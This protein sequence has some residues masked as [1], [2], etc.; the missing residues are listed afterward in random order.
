MAKKTDIDLDKLLQAGA[1]FGHHAK[2]W[3]PRMGEYIYG[4]KDGVHVFDLIK[5]KE[6]LEEA[7]N[8][9]KDAKAKGKVILFLGTKKQVK[10]K[11]KEVAIEVGSPYIDDRFLG[12]TFTNFEQILKSVRKLIEMQTKLAN[13]EYGA[14]TKKEKLLIAREIEKKEKIFGGIKNLTK[15]P[16]VIFV[17]DTHRE[18]GAV[19]EAMTMG[20]T[21]V[22][23]VDTNADPN[24]V[25]YPIPMND[26]ASNALSYVLDLI[27]DALK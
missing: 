19:K 1:H 22:G 24:L 25:N 8:A 17:V 14:Y 10:D 5:T 15:R 16:D 13:G 3:N 12:G 9:L 21:T 23:I 4:L 7:I 6:K 20:I 27:K 26:D 2:R 18:K 11:I